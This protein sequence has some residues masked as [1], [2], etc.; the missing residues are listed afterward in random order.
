MRT[1]SNS[2]NASCRSCVAPQIVSKK[3]KFFCAS[4]RSVSI[5]HGLANSALHFL[6]LAAQHRR[7]IRHAH[8]LQVHVGIKSRGVRASE[9]LEERLFIAAVSDVIA[10]VICIRE[11]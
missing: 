5:D 1:L 11:S 9:F 8:G 7:L 10:N 4:F 6:S 2:R 3:R